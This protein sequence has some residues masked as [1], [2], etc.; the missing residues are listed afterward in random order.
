M[1]GTVIRLWAWY[2]G[3]Q[4]SITPESGIAMNDS[5]IN[6]PLGASE[7]AQLVNLFTNDLLSKQ[8]VLDELQRGGVLD[9]DLVIEDEIERID[10]DKE[11][12]HELQHEEAG[13]KLGED[14]DRA[15]KFQ[16]QAPTQP[17]QGGEGEPASGQSSATKNAQAGQEKSNQA[18]ASAQAK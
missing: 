2:A 7:I 6:K 16:D 5:L 14:L 8:T 11:E 10:E 17:G 1:F 18:K 4:D 12:E 13:Q 3:E 15:K 9:P